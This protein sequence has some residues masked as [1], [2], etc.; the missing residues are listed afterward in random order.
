MKKIFSRLKIICKSKNFPEMIDNTPEEYIQFM[1]FFAPFL[2]MIL[3]LWQL[4]HNFI[5]PEMHD[6]SFYTKAN[7]ILLCAATI[8]V[9]GIILHF[10]KKIRTDGKPSLKNAVKSNIPM[11]FFLFV[12]LMMIISTLINGFTDCALYGDIYRHESLFT[13][14]VYFA[15]YFLSATIITNKKFKSILLYTF[16][17]I[18][19]PVGIF[20]F[21]DYAFVSLEAFDLCAGVSS[22]YHQFNHYGYYLLM[23]I[24]VSAALFVKEK[25]TALRILCLVSFIF[26]NVLLIINDTFGC[27]LACFIALIFNCIVISITEKKFDI[28]S[29]ILLAVFVIITLIMNV[30]VHTIFSN[31]LVFTKDV[32]NIISKPENSENAGTGRWTLWTHTID[33][34]KEK[35][36]FGFGVEG[37]NIR[38]HTDTHGIND[39]PHNEFLQYAA[40][41]GIPAA[42]AYFCGA[43]SVFLNGL[44]NRYKLDKFAV[45]ALVS[46]FAYLVSS[47]FGNTMYYT[48]PY[49]F[50]LLGMGFA[51]SSEENIENSSKI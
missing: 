18:S 28:K 2:F 20:T 44:K 45:A 23:V 31:I 11:V 32:G 24:L 40:F 6:I 41:F 22:V 15:V 9:L 21:I 25:N 42:I 51:K 33:Y 14:I 50:I 16:I 5:S 7:F 34:I 17:I 26:N 39:R 47:F 46:A 29:V 43:F 13:Y 30:W 3:P 4:I 10:A 37:T 35:P 1:M 36:L 48:A 38:L 27:Y 19:L 12:I 49:F 8:G